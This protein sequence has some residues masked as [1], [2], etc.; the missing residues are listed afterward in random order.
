MGSPSVQWSTSWTT[1]LSAQGKS[2]DK[3]NSLPSSLE[4][5]LVIGPQFAA[6]GFRDKYQSDAWAS[7]SLESPKSKK[8][9]DDIPEPANIEH[10]LSKQ[11]L[12][13]TELCRSFGETGACRYGHKCQFAHGLHE[14]RPVLRH[15]KYK[16]ETCKKFATTGQC[17]YGN[18]CRFI[19]PGAAI[20]EDDEQEQTTWS[21][22]WNSLSKPNNEE[23]EEVRCSRLAVFQNIATL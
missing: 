12:Y 10:E 2:V 19:H 16:T 11:N 21:G 4:E 15:P 22:S 6:L 20:D 23:D 14:L 1:P 13:K 7:P 17:P 3:I 9:E 5:E 18:R 8:K